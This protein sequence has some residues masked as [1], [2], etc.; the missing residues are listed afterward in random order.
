MGVVD[1]AKFWLRENPNLYRGKHQRTRE[2]IAPCLHQCV[3][4]L[5]RIFFVD[6]TLTLDW[7]KECDRIVEDIVN[8]KH[9]SSFVDE[10]YKEHEEH[11]L[12]FAAEELRRAIEQR[13]ITHSA[14]EHSWQC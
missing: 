7:Y 8:D 1:T 2:Q 13:G 10:K 12:L 5:A 9:Y 14:I 11:H 4:S 3:W 6:A